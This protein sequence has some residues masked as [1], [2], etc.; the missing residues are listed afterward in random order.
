MNKKLKTL[1]YIFLLPTLVLLFLV[2]KKVMH[3]VELGHQKTIAQVKF[4]DSRSKY[5][6]AVSSPDI[7]KNDRADL[8]IEM[9]D[10]EHEYKLLK[11]GKKLQFTYIK[12][13][14]VLLFIIG[15]ILYRS[16]GA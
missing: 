14:G 11:Y 8:R 4:Y 12:L 7:T 5:E 10:L 13:Y 6:V 2:T 16:R 15:M 3:F 1:G 9:K